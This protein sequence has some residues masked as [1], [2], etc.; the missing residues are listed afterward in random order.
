MKWLVARRQETL[1]K[2]RSNELSMVDAAAQ[3]VNSGMSSN[4]AWDLL[5]RV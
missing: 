1:R 5:S 3:L 4:G 2:W